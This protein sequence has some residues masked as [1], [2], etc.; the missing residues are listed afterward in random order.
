MADHSIAHLTNRLRLADAADWLAVV[1]AV[2]L[3]WSTSATGIL[4]VLLLLALMPTLDW[5][6]IR[7]ELLTLAGGLPVLLVALGVLGM[8]WADV[9]W[10]E[11]W[12]GVTSFFR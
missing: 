10:H 5:A 2:A 8:T 3:P 6:D 9:T 12:G 11:R 7:R 1:T 4:L